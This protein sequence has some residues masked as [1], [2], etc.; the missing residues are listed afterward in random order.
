MLQTIFTTMSADERLSEVAEILATGL[1]RLHAR[2]SS[3]LSPHAGE[4]SLDCAAGQSG[5]ADALSK[6][7]GSLD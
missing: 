6:H 2:K 1:M 5:H 4:G 7:G 3:P